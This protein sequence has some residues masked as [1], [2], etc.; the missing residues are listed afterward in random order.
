M[1]MMFRAATE[2]GRAGSF[3]LV[4]S[5]VASWVSALAAS[6]DRRAAIKQL[7]Q[8]DDRELQDLGI[9]RSQI[10]DAVNGEFRR[11]GR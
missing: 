6:L 9:T 7:Q 11:R 3:P 8:S 4:S 5:W 1:S 2:Q 10:E